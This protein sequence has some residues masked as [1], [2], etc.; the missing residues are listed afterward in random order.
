MERNKT[1][2][3]IVAIFIALSSAA[4]IV[5]A[6][7]HPEPIRPGEYSGFGFGT[8]VEFV[9]DS[10]A[11]LSPGDTNGLAVLSSN[12]PYVFISPGD[13]NVT[14]DLLNRRD[15]IWYRDAVLEINVNIGGLTRELNVY[16]YVFPHHSAGS[17]VPVNYYIL[18]N[19]NGAYNV[20]SAME[21]FGGS[22][23]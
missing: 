3:L 17:V 4:I 1:L 20:V 16:G 22:L 8:I 12:G 6:P 21:V 11:L 2:G 14:A 5:Y 18:V 9:D 10:W 13:V 23:G 15:I 19:A 7:S